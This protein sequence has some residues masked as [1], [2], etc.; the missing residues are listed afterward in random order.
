MNK[1]LLTLVLSEI[2]CCQYGQ[3]CKILLATVLLGIT[4][5]SHPLQAC[6]YIVTLGIS[7]FPSMVIVATMEPFDRCLWHNMCGPHR[8]VLFRNLSCWVSF[9]TPDKTGWYKWN[10]VAEISDYF[11]SPR[12]RLPSHK[13]KRMCIYLTARHNLTGN[14]IVKRRIS[15]CLFFM[16]PSDPN[17]EKSL[18]YDEIRTRKFARCLSVYVSAFFKWTLFC[19]AP[20]L[21]WGCHHEK[22]G[23]QTSCRWLC[24]LGES[25][26][27]Y[28][29]SSTQP[30]TTPATRFCV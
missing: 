10:Q 5:T 22:E 4:P 20:L 26:T 23:V 17:R 24:L 28:L 27:A 19:Q 13:E 7:L 9:R 6:C 29:K 1:D 21:L 18:S 3:C 16:H 30:Q 15:P 11:S 8:F 2:C 25:F 14:Q 12:S